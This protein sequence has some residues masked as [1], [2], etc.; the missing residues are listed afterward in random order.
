[1]NF[2]TL[3]VTLPLSLSLLSLAPACDTSLEDSSL[4]DLLQ[5]EVD[6]ADVSLAE[7]IGAAQAAAPGAV[8][9]DAELDVDSNPV[10][11]D[12]ELLDGDVMREIDISPTDGSVVR[13]RTESLDADDLVEAQADADLAAG[14]SSWAEIIA[15][16]EAEAGGVAFE[17]EADADD[18]VLQVELLVDGV[19]WEVELSADGTVTKSEVSD[20]QLDDSNSNSNSDD[21]DSDDDDSDSDD[22]DSDDDDSDSD[23]DDSLDDD[24]SDDDSDSDDDDSNDDDDDDSNDDD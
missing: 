3:L 24:D 15:T 13:D 18:G 9:I 22:D 6:G 23:D 10:S 11:Y 12:I 16:A 20:D 17:A 8:V 5:D 2:K 19:I 14:A 21:D 4:R 1:M 7:A